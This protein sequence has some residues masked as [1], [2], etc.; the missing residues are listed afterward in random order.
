MTGRIASLGLLVVWA[1]AGQNDLTQLSVAAAGSGAAVKVEE[2]EFSGVFYALSSGKLVPLEREAANVKVNAGGLIMLRAK[3]AMEFPGVA[4]P[5]RLQSGRPLEFIVRLPDG[6]VSTDPD[7]LYHLRVLEPK[8]KNR[9]L[10]ITAGHATPFGA[11]MTTDPSHSIVPVSYSRYGGY[12]V[13]M[14]ATL[15]PGEYAVGVQ[16]GQAVFCFGVD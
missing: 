7:A 13:K 14:T 2:P 4:S 16:H 9:E 1:V 5:I 8:K 15:G 3:G 11:S 10:V 12:S 6:A